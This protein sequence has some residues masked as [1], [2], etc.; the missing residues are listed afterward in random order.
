MR[1]YDV[2]I[3]GGGAGGIAAALEARKANLRTLLIEKEHLGGNRVWYGCVPS[4]ALVAASHRINDVRNAYLLGL[5]K[6]EVTLDF[7]HLMNRVSEVQQLA[8]KQI[9]HASLIEQGVSVEFCKPVFVDHN[10][11]LL[12]DTAVS[13]LHCIIATG[14]RPFIP[15]IT[16]IENS[17]YLTNE[18]IFNL[19]EL[20]KSIVFIGG[21]PLGTELS[22]VFRRFGSD[23]TLIAPR[24]IMPREDV[25]LA[26]QLTEILVAEGVKIIDEEVFQIGS[27]NNNKVVYLGIKKDEHISCDQVFIATGRVPNIEGIGIENIKIAYNN[28]GIIVNDFLQT[29]VSNIYAI[30]DVIGGPQYAHMAVSNAHTAIANILGK[31]E[32]QDKVVPWV[33]FTDPEFSRV[34]ITQAQALVQGKDHHVLSHKFWMND[35]ALCEEKTAGIIKVIVEENGTILGASILG[36]NAGELIQEYV[37]AMRHNLKMQDLASTIHCYPTLSDSNWLIAK[38]NESAA[39]FFKMLK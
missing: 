35:R 24:G 20:P 3:I 22:Q 2:V 34:G 10:T 23:V 9:D 21:G 33:T 17:G 8:S 26:K 30:G 27:N 5:P 36:S 38:S 15:K 29:S 28:N 14:S 11:L 6:I 4:K 12:R 39:H 32:K 13:F 25:M 37:V 19:K 7:A 31:R 1:E 16:G 18:T